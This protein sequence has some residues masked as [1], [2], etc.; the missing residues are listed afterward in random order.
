MLLKLIYVDTQQRQ[1]SSCDP[2]IYTPLPM[3]LYMNNLLDPI[4]KSSKG[5]NDEAGNDSPR[6]VLV[7]QPFVYF[8]RTRVAA[9]A[10]VGETS[11]YF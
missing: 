9:K 8:F 6:L 5:E 4:K 2:Y 10:E 7:S 3:P 1:H 11:K